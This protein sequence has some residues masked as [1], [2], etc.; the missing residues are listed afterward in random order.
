M[1]IVATIQFWGD[2]YGHIHQMME[3]D[4]TT[5]DNT[6]SVL[7]LDIANPVVVILLYLIAFQPPLKDGN[8]PASSVH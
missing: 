4:N 2:A 1:I 5:P 8:P 3:Y 6:G 7:W